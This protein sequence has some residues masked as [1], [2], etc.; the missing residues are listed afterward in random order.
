MAK[1]ESITHEVVVTSVQPSNEFKNQVV[2]S[3][4]TDLIQINEDGKEEKK[5][6]FHIDLTR[7]QIILQT[8]S[9]LYKKSQRR[10]SNMNVTLNIVAC[11]LDGAKIKIVREFAEE[12]TPR[13]YGT[14]VYEHDT[15]TTDIVEI[16]DESIDD[17]KKE[18]LTDLIKDANTMIAAEKAN[19]FA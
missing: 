3:V 7:L 14:G 11:I 16:I 15:Y 5:R 18:E 13:K 12:N 2:I 19:F 4:D 8:A 9:K 1:R 6:Y 17:D 10:I